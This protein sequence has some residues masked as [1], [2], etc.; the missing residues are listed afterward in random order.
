MKTPTIN[1]LLSTEEGKEQ[2]NELID[3]VLDEIDFYKIHYVMKKLNW[4]W[5]DSKEID[6]IP[7]PIELRDFLSQNLYE[8]F[9]G[10]HTYTSFDCGGFYVRYFIELPYDDRV[11]IDFAHCVCLRVS[12]ELETF[13]NYY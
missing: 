9:N 2:M 8:M 1:E 12:F 4:T 13:N 3:E 6:K 11:P 7:T 10:E 5:V